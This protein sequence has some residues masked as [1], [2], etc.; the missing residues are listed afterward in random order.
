MRAAQALPS[1][2]RDLIPHFLFEGC[3]GT[4]R[5]ILHLYLCGSERD[6]PLHQKVVRHMLSGGR[7]TKMEIPIW[8]GD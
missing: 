3:T 5:D 6:S 4:F 2:A 1:A 8:T 7:E